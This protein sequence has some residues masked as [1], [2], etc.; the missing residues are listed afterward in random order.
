MAFPLG[1][2]CSV[3]SLRESFN[4]L[5]SR[6]PEDIYTGVGTAEN[7]GNPWFLCTAAMAEL[8]YSAIIEYRTAGSINV[9]S[10]S[11]PFFNYYTP[12]AKV[13]AGKTYEASSA[14][15]MSVI[16]G[17]EGW[18]DAYMRRIKYHM[19]GGGHLP[20]EFNRQT[21]FAQGATDLTWSYASL[22][23]AAFARAQVIGNEGYITALANMDTNIR[24]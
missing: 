18:A 8:L 7:G 23:T 21:G 9:T 14:Q 22:L 10:I 6:Y 17:L 13:A 19:P 12:A 4:L 16:A 15:F 1:K 2:S 5:S 24:T 20:E 11:L 3:N